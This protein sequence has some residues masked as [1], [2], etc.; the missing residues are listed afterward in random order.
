MAQLERLD[1]NKAKLTIKVEAPVFANALREAYKKNV[2]RYTVQGFRK[3]KAPRKVIENCYGEAVFY[4]DAFELCWGEAYDAALEEHT[5]FAVDRPDIDILTISEAD[6]IEFTATVQL[7]PEATLGQY[8]GVVVPAMDVTVTDEDVEKVL[9]DEREKQARFSDV[10]REAQ[11]GDRLLLDY[12]GSVDGEKF[13]GGTA[14]DQTLVLGSHAF[15]PGFEEQLIG[16]KA[17][18]QR[19]ITVTFPEEYHA[20]ELAG[21]EAVFACNIKAVQVKE[22]PEI[23]D[24]FIG[25]I[26][27]FETLEAWKAD[28]KAK[29]E[30][31]KKNYAKTMLENNALKTACD[32]ATVEIPDCMIER[33][34]D[35]ML[36]DLQYRLSGSGLDLNTYCQYVGTTPEALRDTYREEAAVRVKMQLVIDAVVAAEGIAATDEDVEKITVRYAEESGIE[37]ETFRNQLSDDDREYLADRAAVEKAVALITESA[38]EEAVEA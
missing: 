28:K 20:N 5:L 14:E 1:G 19:D 7:K 11:E 2:N 38:V 22:L 12:S 21:K 35:Y 34:I 31:D 15:I 25:D 17:G 29:L 10:D 36:R 26:S 13:G 33:Q 27:E 8:K 3:G 16:V 6:G 18:E 24:D 9:N 23:D 37:L 32:N 4:E 30:E